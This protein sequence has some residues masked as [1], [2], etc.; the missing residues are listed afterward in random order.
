MKNMIFDING[1]EFLLNNLVCEKAGGVLTIDRYQNSSE[2]V[3]KIMQ[4]T[5]VQQNASLEFPWSRSL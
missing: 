2:K 4:M 3:T 1:K 5:F